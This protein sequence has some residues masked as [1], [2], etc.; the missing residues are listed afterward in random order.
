VGNFVDL[1]F[2][3]KSIP[4]ML[5]YLPVTL[6]LA[7]IPMIFG[8]LI[9]LFVALIKIYKVPVLKQLAFIY[10]SFIRGT[11][12]LVQL[13]IVYYGLFKLLMALKDSQSWLH[14]FDITAVRP[15]YYAVLAFSINLGAYLSETLRAAIESVDRGQFEA[16]HSMGMSQSQI[17]LKIILPQAALVALPNM[18][19]TLISMVKDTSFAF[20]IMIV[21]VMGEAKI[22]G[23]RGLRFFEVYVGVSLIYWAVCIILERFLAVVEKRLRVNERGITE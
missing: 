19:N 16:A 21:D 20:M 17:M 8:T 6:M 2:I 14:G 10:V 15:E 13:Y 9:G 5:A 7:I 3:A 12:L 4:Q 18:G 1:D 23:A 11:P 22:I